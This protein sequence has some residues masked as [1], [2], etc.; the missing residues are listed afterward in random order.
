[1]YVV[2]FK[3]VWACKVFRNNYA[4]TLSLNVR[5]SLCIALFVP[6]M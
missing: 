6:Y 5:M 4:L 2:V 1:M 3:Q